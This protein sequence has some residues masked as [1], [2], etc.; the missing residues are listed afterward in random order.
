MQKRFQSRLNRL[1]KTKARDAF[2]VYINA[3]TYVYD[4]HTNYFSPRS[5]EDFN[6]SFN[7]SLEGI[8]AVLTMDNDYVEI[9]SLVPGGPAEQEGQLKPKDRI[10]SISQSTE[11]PFI[12]VVGWRLDDVVDLIRGPKG[13]IVVLEVLTEEGEVEQTRR[14]PIQRDKVNL[15]EERAKKKILT[16]NHNGNDYKIGVIEVKKFYVDMAAESRRVP[17][18][19]SVTRDVREIINELNEEN[20]D[21]VLLDLRN[22]GGGSLNEAHKL[23][24]LFVE[25]G[26][27][28]QVQGKGNLQVFRD[29]D[30]NMAWSGPLA[31]IVNRQ[32]ASASEIVA[33][34]IQDYK[35]GLILGNRTYGKGTVQT[36]VPLN[37]GQLKVTQAKYYRITG[38]STQHEGVRP[39]IE[40]PSLID[41]DEIGES[42]IDGAMPWTTIAAI[43]FA[44][45]TDRDAMVDR[46]LDIHNER[47]Q[48]DPYFQYYAQV[49][50]RI[51]ENKK[52]THVSLNEEKRQKVKD[53]HD[54]W[55]LDV[56]NALLVATGEKPVATID[57]LEDRLKALYEKTKDDSDAIIKE[58]GRIL[59]DYLNSGAAVAH[60]TPS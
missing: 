9:S 47:I 44:R 59:L 31:V 56:E 38:E 14:I 37:Q 5:S 52:I 13:T 20:V 39:D 19:R 58:S 35:R 34:A 54:S 10:V 7:L 26:P 42:T 45:F 2:S 55:R 25:S 57:E 28:V 21:G 41:I 23:T 17:N 43:P 48:D 60:V 27:T 24:S 22:N 12:D 30:E 40:Y 33:G 49:S 50:Q 15:N 53:D 11:G 16:L 32:S 36:L 6:M 3:F 4:P 29:G 51:E 18:Y 1:Q 8:G 46:L